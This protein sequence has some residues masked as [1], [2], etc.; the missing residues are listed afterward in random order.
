M[1]PVMASAPRMPTDSELAIL[2]ILWKR[3]P[4]TV[5]QVHDELNRSRPTGYTTVLKLMQ[6]MYAKGLLRRDGSRRSHVFTPKPSEQHTQKQLVKDLLDRAF[7]G[8][9]R[10]LVMSALSAGKSSQEEL[11]EIRA[12][13]DQMK[14][15][16]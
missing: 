3:G 2:A 15:T 10:K 5:R 7:G 1:V 14:S 16:G 8:S 12:L 11:A 9:A 6:I 13:L 4:S